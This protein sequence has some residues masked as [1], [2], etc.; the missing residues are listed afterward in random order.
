VDKPR[1]QVHFS[2]GSADW[3]RTVT[4]DQRARSERQSLSVR[5]QEMLNHPELPRLLGHQLGGKNTRFKI[6]SVR[7]GRVA[8]RKIGKPFAPSAR[9]GVGSSAFR[10]IRVANSAS[11]PHAGH[12]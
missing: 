3:E 11:E 10:G 5:P 7:N 4:S 8:A 12:N 2:V 1:K 9:K 6:R